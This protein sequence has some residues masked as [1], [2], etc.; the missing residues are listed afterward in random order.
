MITGCDD[1]IRI[2]AARR[3]SQ[4]QSHCLAFKGN[5]PATCSTPDSELCWCTQDIKRQ[6]GIEVADVTCCLMEF[7]AKGAAGFL[8]DR[9]HP[10][11]VTQVLR[12]IDRAHFTNAP[13]PVLSG[14]RRILPVCRYRKTRRLQWE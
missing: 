9:L 10:K 12:V 5:L 7:A 2:E 4:A 6:R 13:G 8:P 14:P 11:Q 1:H 3:V